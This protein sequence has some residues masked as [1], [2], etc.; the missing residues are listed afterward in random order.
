VQHGKTGFVAK[1]FDEF[2][3][4]TA[5]LLVQPELLAAMREAARR[6]ALSTS[7]SGSSRIMYEAYDRCLYAANR[8]GR[9]GVLDVATT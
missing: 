8:V 6:Y 3:A 5:I 1:N 4:C 7:W 2:V 9:G